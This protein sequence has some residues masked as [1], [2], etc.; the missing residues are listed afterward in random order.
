MSILKSFVHALSVKE[1]VT[2]GVT[3]VAIALLIMGISVPLVLR[4]VP[5]NIFYGVRF[6]QSYKSKQNWYEINER[7]GR[8]LIYWCIPMFLFGL[9]GVVFPEAVKRMYFLFWTSGMTVWVI[10]ICLHCYLMARQVDKRN[11]GQE[12]SIKENS[13]GA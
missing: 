8:I 12:T 11:A 7:G 4:R 13:Q 10:V 5:M 9:C 1:T 6:P 2:L 3:T